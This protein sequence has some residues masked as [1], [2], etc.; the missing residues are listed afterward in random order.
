MNK[1][2]IAKLFTNKKN[3]QITLIVPKKQ[4]KFPKNKTPKLLELK[5]EKVE[6]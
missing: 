1:K 6:W 5:I 3:K 4:I 2:F